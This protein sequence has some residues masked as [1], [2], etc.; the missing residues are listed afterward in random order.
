MRSGLSGRVRLAMMGISGRQAERQARMAK[1]HPET[2]AD[3]RRPGRP[4]GRS[5]SR[6]RVLT[7]AE[8]LFAREGIDRPGL[9]RIAA[10]AGIRA[11]SLIHLFASRDGLL[12]AVVERAARDLDEALAHARDGK[13][14]RAR[15]LA[16]ARAH[17]DR[18]RLLVTVMLAGEAPAEASE[19]AAARR[20]AMMAVWP[21]RNALHRLRSSAGLAGQVELALLLSTLAFASATAPLFARA[22]GVENRRWL[23]E[24][25][26][27]LDRL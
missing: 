12:D 2:A 7:A 4:R 19:N 25:E 23:A 3:R 24:L 1:K 26:R 5:D 11:S 20:R 6:L 10:A 9:R 21:L 17:P 13:D 18:L 16:W 22:A 27:M 8:S 14:L 15:L